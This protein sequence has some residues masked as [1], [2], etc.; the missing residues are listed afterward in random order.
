M[1]DSKGYES[2]DTHYSGDSLLATTYDDVIVRVREFVTG[3]GGAKPRLTP[4][5]GTTQL[6]YRALGPVPFRATFN[7]PCHTAQTRPPW[8]KGRDERRT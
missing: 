3:T 4:R 5:Y 7:R 2:P 1:I 6:R 8:K